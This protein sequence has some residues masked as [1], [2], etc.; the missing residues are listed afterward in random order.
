MDD[1]AIT[2]G[3][4]ACDHYTTPGQRELFYTTKEGKFSMYIDAVTKK[5]GPSSFCDSLL[6]RPFDGLRLNSVKSAF[7][8]W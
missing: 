6:M 5:M 2:R 4:I 7:A 3:L 8:K 1:D